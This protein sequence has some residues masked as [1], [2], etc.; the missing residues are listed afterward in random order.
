MAKKELWVDIAKG[1][2]IIAVVLGHS[3]SKLTP[4]LYWFHM[5]AFFILSGYLFKPL[6]SYGAVKDYA[7]R[8]AK[9][10]FLPYLAFLITVILMERYV[11]YRHGLSLGIEQEE[12]NNWIFGGS[13]LKGWFGPFWFIT[14][15]YLTQTVFA[16]LSV[17]VQSRTWLVGL[18]LTGSYFLA[19]LE[20]ILLR[21][22]RVVV[23]W[24]ADVMLLAV[25]YF[26]IGYFARGFVQRYASSR[27][28]FA[29]SSLLTVGYILLHRMKIMGFGLDMKYAQYNHLI[30]DLLVPL[31]MT[32]AL[33]GLSQI[34]A[35]WKFANLLALAGTLSMPIMYLHIPV[36]KLLAEYVTY[37]EVIFTLVGVLVPVLLTRWIFARFKLTQKYYLGNFPEERPVQNLNRQ[38]SA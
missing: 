6:S 36:N 37:H 34:L 33:I 27:L 28:V 19:H 1:L 20:S 11:R 31:T 32:L 13:N 29:L 38:I 30:L 7:F 25:V 4:Y 16:F 14:C 3:G 26:A 8:K 22:H 9:R 15:M 10:F 23:P 18:V 5:P 24:G 17:N 35:Q 21:T 12:L 2:G